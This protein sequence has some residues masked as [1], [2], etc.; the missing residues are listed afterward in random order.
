MPRRVSILIV[1][2]A[3]LSLGLLATLGADSVSWVLPAAVAALGTV[4]LAPR[5]V[6][7]GA[8]S[9]IAVV[10]LAVFDAGTAPG[11]VQWAGTAFAAL[12]LLLA[13]V[14]S[15]P[16]RLD[17]RALIPLA[18][19]T[20]YL[21]LCV[22]GAVLNGQGG[23][24]AIVVRSLGGALAVGVVLAAGG[25]LTRR[26]FARGVVYFGLVQS[27]LAAIGAL[28]APLAP[29]GFFLIRSVRTENRIT[30]FGVREQ[31]LS[32]HPIA[33]T[34]LTLAALLIVAGAWTLWSVRLRLAAG[35]LLLLGVVLGGSRTAVAAGLAVVVATAAF[36][37]AAWLRRRSRR[38]RVTAA[39]GASLLLLAVVGY[40]AVVLAGMI[41]SPSFS[42][43]AGVVGA[44]PGLLGERSLP[45]LLFGEGALG[46]LALFEAGRLGDEGWWVI[47]NQFVSSLIDGGLVG[48]ALFL[49]LLART[50][51]VGDLTARLLVVAAAAECF[52][53]DLLLWSGLTACL[54]ATCVLAERGGA[55]LDDHPPRTEA[56]Q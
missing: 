35:A 24:A 31:V 53:I 32:G 2:A 14:R 43:R 20:A 4:V 27:V 28:G 51:V 17:R 50:I 48:L 15:R 40:A 46:S 19:V 55:G 38:V 44:V 8:T 49:A 37:G 26:V 52:S 25:A 30:G 45:A 10:V 39:A 21:L 22:S 29:F 23:G 16:W 5:P 1:I 56:P 13:L 6:V 7:A 3:T 18:L 54:V 34:V 41:D 11:A 12:L 42:H 33:F 36:G 47:D 9:A